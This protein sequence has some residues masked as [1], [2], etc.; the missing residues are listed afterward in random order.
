MTDIYTRSKPGERRDNAAK[1]FPLSRLQVTV[2]YLVSAEIIDSLARKYC[3]ISEFPCR[4]VARGLR[5]FSLPAVFS[6]DHWIEVPWLS[7]TSFDNNYSTHISTSE[8]ND[9]PKARVLFYAIELSV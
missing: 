2:C 9:C 4:D 6:D 5:L 7:A 1:G 8:Q 3:D